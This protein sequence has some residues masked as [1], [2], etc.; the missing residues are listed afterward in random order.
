MSGYPM[1]LTEAAQ[2][3]MRV[4]RDLVRDGPDED[5]GLP[6]SVWLRRRWRSFT[7]LGAAIASVVAFDA[8]LAT[9]GFQGCPSAAEIRAFRPPEGGR[10]L[11]ASG[12]SMGRLVNI[13][14]INIALDKIPIHVQR[15]FIATEDRRF[16][17]HDGLDL[18][19][20]ARAAVRNASSFGV[21]EGFSTI[22][23]Q[24][25]RNAFA[26]RR[27]NQRT[28][29]R[30]LIELRLARLLERNLDKDQILELYLNV[31]YLGNGTYG[32]EAASRDL[33]G[34]GVDRLSVSEAAML[35]ALPKGPSSYTPRRHPQRAQQRRD[36]V[37]SLMVREGFI[38]DKTA[39]A[40]VSTPLRV[41]AESKVIVEEDSYGLDAV[42]RMVD[43]ILAQSG[44][45]IGDVTVHTTLDPVAQ[46]AADRA[47][48]RRVAAIERETRNWY[49]RVAQSPQGAMVA[50]DPR[51]GDIR[52]LVGGARYQRGGF[53]RAL[54]ARRQPGSAFKPFV[55]AAAL[56]AGLTPATMVDD[57]PVEVQE[58]RTIWTPA[59]YGDEYQGRVTLRRALMRSSNAATVRVSRAVGEPRVIAAAQRNGIVSPLTPVPSIALGALEVTP[60]ELVA[61]YAP[62]ANG[63]YRVTP[64]LIR[65]IEGAGGVTLWSQEPQTALVMDARDAFQL[66]SM[67]RS[68]V[69]QGTGSVVREY[70]VSGP[71]AGKTGT[72]NNGSDVWFVGYTPTLVAGFWFGYDTPRPISGNAA[73]GRLAAPAWA[74]FYLNG[75]RE[76]GTESAWEPPAGLEMH[77]IDAQTGELAGAWCPTRQR[78]WFKPGT[79]PTTFCREHDNWWYAEPWSGEIPSRV[80]DR[81]GRTLRR[82]FRY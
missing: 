73:G 5:L 51:T 81:I 74:E 78:E 59:N 32:V 31:I 56:S 80:A 52:A 68:A 76:R 35:A 2:H 48:T 46:R 11:D 72:T 27:F 30:K 21:R 29:R 57:E 82:I 71:V 66:T 40:A 25:A 20:F 28:V 36:L 26:A 70:G 62:F 60:L 13:R 41:A 19:G 3:R 65:R 10:I 23:M 14:R 61:A 6:A 75:W 47:V 44:V 63:G 50:L 33:F 17:Q 16:Y 43:S 7:L 58:G 38:T 34:K 1:S 53:N 22:T 55:Y 42:R 69:D 67:L 12:Q 45:D 39:E 9:C 49:G 24:V 77:E 54:S 37:L 4:F 79:E 18:R 64:R 8:W 15:A